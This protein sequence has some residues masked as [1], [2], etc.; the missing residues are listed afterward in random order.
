MGQWKTVLGVNLKLGLLLTR[1]GGRSYNCCPPLLQKDIVGTYP[2]SKPNIA[3]P[4]NLAGL[5]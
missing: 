4:P 5:A 3:P 2:P 1:A